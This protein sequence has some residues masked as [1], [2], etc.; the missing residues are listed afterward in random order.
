METCAGADCLDAWPCPACCPPPERHCEAEGTF[1]W[2]KAP[3]DQLPCATFYTDGSVVDKNVAGCS[4]AAWAFA[5][6]DDQGGLVAAA[7]GL[8]PNWI[9]EINGAEAWAILSAAR[10]AGPGSTY[11]T[12]SLNCVKMMCK[13]RKAA[14][15][16]RPRNARLWGLLQGI[17]DHVDDYKSLIWMPSHRTGTAV[18]SASKGDGTKLT[19]LDL[20]GNACADRLAKKTAMAHRQSFVTRAGIMATECVARAMAR[21]VGWVTWAGNHCPLEVPRDAQTVNSKRRRAQ[22]GEVVHGKKGIVVRPRGQSG[23][24]DMTS[25]KWETVGNVGRACGPV[26]G[27]SSCSM[28]NVVVQLLCGGPSWRRLMALRPRPL[29]AWPGGVSTTNGSLTVSPGAERAARMLCRRPF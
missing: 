3:C 24:G 21:Y 14:T 26:P 19:E 13:G 18:G 7:S 28:K 9:M 6:Y 4:V 2:H 17:F 11:I 16:A 23:L 12:D 5:A 1:V 25:I 29:A 22:D 8:T 15:T 10:N 20:R 27:W